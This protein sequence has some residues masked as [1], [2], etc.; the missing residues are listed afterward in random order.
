MGQRGPAKTPTVLNELRGNPGKRKRNHG[1]PMPAVGERV[2]SAPRWL[3][4]GG[5]RHWRQLA[6]RLHAVGLLTEVD[7]VGLAMLCEALGQ[8]LEAR[9][10]VSREGMVAISDKGNAYHHPAL[11]QMNTARGEV[12]RWAQQFGMTPSS[13]S[14]ISVEAKGEELSLVD[15]L[16]AAL[17]EGADKGR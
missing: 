6:P 2:P 8:Y 1:E 4:E 14:R 15:V 10:L 7:V 5:R 11:A 17:F 13:R 12:L 9:D 3:G 16:A